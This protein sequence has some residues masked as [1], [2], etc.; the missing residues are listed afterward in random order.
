MGDMPMGLCPICEDELDFED[1][2]ICDTCN[3]PFCWPHC[4][5][6]GDEGHECSECAEESGG[7]R[8]E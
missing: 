7:D 5:G 6:W 1:A 8:D 3:R 4:G 2:G